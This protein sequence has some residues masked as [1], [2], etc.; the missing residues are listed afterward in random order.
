M[1]S[2]QVIIRGVCYSM[3]YGFVADRGLCFVDKLSGAGSSVVE[4]TCAHASCTK[5]YLI[6]R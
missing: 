5:L 6:N 1:S 2:T 4:S 3:Y